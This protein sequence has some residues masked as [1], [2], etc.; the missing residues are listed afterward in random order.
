MT[1][2]EASTLLGASTGIPFASMEGSKIIQLPLTTSTV[3]DENGQ[4]I[5]LQVI[6]L[7]F[8]QNWRKK[9]TVLI[10]LCLLVKY[11]KRITILFSGRRDLIQWKNGD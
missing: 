10:F 2:I 5:Q 3:V 8:I 9:L 1:P 4:Q 7:V 6:Q 11:S